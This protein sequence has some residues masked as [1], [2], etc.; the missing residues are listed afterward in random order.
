M[1]MFA[2][3]AFLTLTIALMVLWVWLVEYRQVKTRDPVPVDPPPD[4]I[5]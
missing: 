1:K 3:G 2:A 4:V 5:D